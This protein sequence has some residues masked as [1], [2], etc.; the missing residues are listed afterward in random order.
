MKNGFDG[1]IEKYTRIGREE[2]IHVFIEDKVEDG[3]PRDTIKERL[4]KRFHIN[5]DKAEEYLL[6]YSPVQTT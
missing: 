2:G 3:I 4:I 6:Q 1:I 5:A